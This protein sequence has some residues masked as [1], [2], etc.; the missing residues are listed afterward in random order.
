MQPWFYG[1]GASGVPGDW[2][3]NAE[4]GFYDCGMQKVSV[5]ISYSHDSDEHRSQVLALSERL[6]RDGIE[7]SLDQYVNGTPTEGWPRWMLNQLDA[8]NFVLIVCTQT[9][10]RRFRGQEEPGKGKGVDWEGAL[11]TQSIYDSRSRTLKFVP[12]F[13]SGPVE[14]WIPEPLRSGTHYAL[15]SEDAYGRLYDFLLEQAGVEPGPLGAFK[16]KPRRKGTALTF[17]EASPPEAAKRDISR[18]THAAE[19]LIGRETEL[20]RLDEAW[21]DSAQHVLVI[22]GIGGEGKT[23]LVVEWTNQ[24]AQRD[25]DGASYF[26]WSFYNQGTR[27]QTDVSSDP[28][29]A[30]ALGFFG[31]DAGKQLANSAASAP[32]K[33][34]KLLEYVRK[35]RTLLVLDGLE[36][37]QYPPGPLAGCLRDGGAM[38]VLLKGLAQNNPGLCVVTTRAPVADLA[39]WQD[40][41]A[42]E[43][44][45][46][47][48]SEIAGAD[49]LQRLL[50]PQKPRNVHQVRSTTEERKEISR[51]VKGHA[52]TLRLLG[53][54]IHRALRDVRRWREVDYSKA[55]A[56]FKINPKDPDARYGHAFKTIEAYEHWLASGGL[57]TVRQR[58]VLRLLGLFDRPASGAS[59]AALRAPPVIADLTESLCGITDD[60]WNTTLSEL[61]EC[62]LV[63][64]PKTDSLF[65]S[66]HIPSLD[67][68][69]LLREYFARQ[70]RTQQPEAWRAAHRRVFEH[71]CATTKEGDQPTLED[72][73]PLYQAVAHGCQAGMHQY[74]CD[75]VYRDRIQ[76][77]KEA[78]S[79][80]KLGAF[81]ADLGAVACFF[82]PP[83]SRVSPELT[84]DA[85]AWLLTVAAFD[86]R[87]LGRLTEALEPLRAGIEVTVRLEDWCNAAISAS[88]LSELELTLG[89]L[90]GAVRDAEQSVTYADRSG[91]DWQMFITSCSTHADALH[92][93]GRRAEAQARFGEAEE[94]QAES[95]P[96][97]PLLYSAQGF[98]YCDLL[99]A[100]PEGAAWQ[101]ILGSA[102]FQT[103]VSGIVPETPRRAVADKTLSFHENAMV[104][105]AQAARRSGQ[106]ARAPEIQSR[107]A[108][109]QRAAQ[110]LKIAEDNN[111]SLLT[112]ALDH[113]TLG[114]AALYEAILEGS[115]LVPCHSSLQHAVNGL[116]RASR[117][118]Y[119]PCGLLTRAWLRSLN[120]PRTGPDSAQSDLDE[121]WDI[122]E[123][124]PMPLFLA[125]IHLYRARLFGPHASGTIGEPYPWESPAADLAAAR[126]LIK[127][128]GYWRR[129]E[130][131][132]DAEA[133]AR[134]WVSAADPVRLP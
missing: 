34:A 39:R 61:E 41:T 1:P 115:S 93:A 117:Q 43:W 112:I 92:Q 29:I 40:S 124:G 132:E 33:A 106:D 2:A 49:L 24:L 53:G 31:G 80:K 57:A 108:V 87:A 72:L 127:K 10:Y 84:E 30:A 8:A 114:R 68:H 89:E 60:E 15:T 123:R 83:W 14:D 35:H 5:F 74:A 77:G 55:D 58:A 20:K 99:L 16:T 28:L 50:E 23:S 82:E 76:R 11:I 69:P 79:T 88:N 9:Y 128:H 59:L 44:E 95:Q 36:P 65:L 4:S 47:H 32:D 22:R 63:A 86:L 3:E 91:D 75:K 18:L 100:A 56:Q 110:T 103:A 96:D 81:G 64:H 118:D 120:G 12:V 126:Q 38:T 105:A 85:Q 7:T 45:L 37:L 97:Y 133:A 129:K 121:A 111:L 134:T 131:L 94:M 90:A 125:D 98:Q 113:L 42:P 17:G 51:A 62:G 70:L 101:W 66:S 102:G 104:S 78:Y 73:Q 67:A 21:N 54:F 130:E 48:L 107:R 27:D 109:S 19:K 26:E 46:E 25:Y 52:L 6:R 119:L 116:C 13:L 71:L 122:A